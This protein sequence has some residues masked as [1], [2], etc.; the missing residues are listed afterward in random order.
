MN[1]KNIALGLVL[2]VVGAT[3]IPLFADDKKYDYFFMEAARQQAAGKYSE[4][5]S[6]LDHA[7]KINPNAAEVYYYMALYYSQMKKR[8]FGFGIFAESSVIESR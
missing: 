1:V 7:R 2:L 4:A 6:L 8:L 3:V 5:F